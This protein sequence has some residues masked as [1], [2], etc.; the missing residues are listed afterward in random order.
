[1][2]KAY[3]SDVLGQRTFQDAIARLADA[4]P[5]EAVVCPATDC[6]C[7]YRS[8]NFML[9][10]REANKATL[11]L[12]SS[13]SIRTTPVRCSSSMKVHRGD[14]RREVDQ[15]ALP[16]SVLSNQRTCLASIRSLASLTSSASFFG[17]RS[18]DAKLHSS[19]HFSLFSIPDLWR[20]TVP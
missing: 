18:P 19:I 16:R 10:D 4:L 15:F 9:E 14:E 8:Y 12:N 3:R 2:A 17:S 7:V 6:D 1:M 20:K 13:A 5:P 11:E